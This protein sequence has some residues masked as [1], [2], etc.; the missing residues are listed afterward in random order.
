MLSAA[1]SMLSAG[2]CVFPCIESG[3]DTDNSLV[4]TGTAPDVTPVSSDST[5]SVSGGTGRESAAAPDRPAG[6][7]CWADATTDVSAAATFRFLTALSVRFTAPADVAKKTDPI[8]TASRNPLMLFFVFVY[9]R[10]QKKND[11]TCEYTSNIADMKIPP[12]GSFNTA[13]R[14]KQGRRVHLQ[15]NNLK[16]KGVFPVLGILLSSSITGKTGLLRYFYHRNG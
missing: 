15:Y 8:H 1:I 10:D 11:R 5:E 12:L 9:I 6:A 13:L 16:I 7:C 4:T 3:F 2:A 14:Q